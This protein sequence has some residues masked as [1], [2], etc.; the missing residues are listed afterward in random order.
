MEYL[1]EKIKISCKIDV[2]I[3]W[4]E[5]IAK[6]TFVQIQ[7][8][9]LYQ[10]MHYCLGNIFTGDLR[11][12]WRIVIFFFLDKLRTHTFGE[13]QFPNYVNLLQFMTILRWT[14]MTFSATM[15][16]RNQIPSFWCIIPVKTMESYFYTKLFFI[17]FK[18][19]KENAKNM[20][21]LRS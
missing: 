5:K 15:R 20:R 10:H 13:E 21:T 7:K 12:L 1:P 8:Y 9:C 14:F 11:I 17:A 18:F 4:L 16:K 6:N 19:A 2:E 3:R